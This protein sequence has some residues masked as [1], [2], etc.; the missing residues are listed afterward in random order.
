M[1]APRRNAF[2]PCA[3]PRADIPRGANSFFLGPHRY[4]DAEGGAFTAYGLVLP[5]C[6][7]TMRLEI[8]KPKPVPPFWRVL[9]LSTC[10]NSSKIFS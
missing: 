1:P 6:I 10:W 3:S 2:A 5:P 9:L 7:S 8:A 4:H